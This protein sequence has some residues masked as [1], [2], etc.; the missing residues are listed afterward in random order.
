MV[1]EIMERI[2]AYDAEVG[3]AG[4]FRQSVTDSAEIWN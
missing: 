4:L 3:Q 1:N 2:A